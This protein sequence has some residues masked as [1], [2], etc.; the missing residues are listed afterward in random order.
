MQQLLELELLEDANHFPVSEFRYP[1]LSRLINWH[2]DDLIIVT[3]VS[4]TLSQNTC[5][6]AGKN[7]EIA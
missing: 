1:Q 4:K 5:L 7:T 2:D 3:S 6:K